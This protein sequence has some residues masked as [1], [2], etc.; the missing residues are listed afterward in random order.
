MT[1]R[2]FCLKKSIDETA[3]N[4]GADAKSYKR[5]VEVLARNFDKL[6][7]DVLAPLQI[8]RNPFFM[9]GFGLK[10]FH[11]AKGLA[12]YYFKGETRARAM[13]A[14][15]AAHSM[16]P[17]EDI[18]SAA[19]GLMLTLLGHSA[20][21]GFPR[22]G[23]QNLSD[24]LA[25]YFQS[26]GGKIETNRR[27]ENIDDLPKSQ[28]VLFD[29]TPRQIIKIA[30]HRLP[31]NYKKRLATYKY[32]AGVFKMD[33]AL[34]EPIPW[35]AK[36][37]LKAGTVHFGGTFEEI[38]RSEREHERREN[39]RKTF[40]FARPTHAFRRNTRTRRKTHRVGILSRSERLDRRYDRRN[41]K[42]DRTFRAR[43]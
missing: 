37:C 2:P 26:L 10:A 11:S 6:A 41:R 43:I 24:A 15:N 28:T 16:I 5:L 3:K 36:D 33:F 12:D 39:L 32:G 30:G 18:P 9:M 23:T 21:W 14:G 8:P 17:L 7:P 27:V 22:G 29:I 13:F 4:L 25:K 1:V 19:F 31:E 40:C 34:S 20:G 38:A 42:P 35:K